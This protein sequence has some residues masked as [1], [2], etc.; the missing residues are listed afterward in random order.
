MLFC[1]VRVGSAWNLLGVTRRNH[2]R[3]LS[4]KYLGIFRSNFIIIGGTYVVYSVILL[5]LDRQKMVHTI[6][7]SGGFVTNSVVF[8]VW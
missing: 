5:I 1:Y 4:L 8:T 6:N 3:F 2:I 7:Y